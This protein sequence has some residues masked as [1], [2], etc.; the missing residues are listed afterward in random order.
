M[1]GTTDHTEL[2]SDLPHDL[3]TT[4]GSLLQGGAGPLL[5]PVRAEIFG[6]QRF[7]EHGQ[8]LGLTHAAGRAAWSSPSFF[9]RLRSN[10]GMLRLARQALAAQ[11]AAGDDVSPASLW[12]LDNFHLIEAQLLA[13]HEGLPRQYFRTLPVLLGEPLAG[14]PRIYGVAWAFVAH[15]DSAFDEDLLVHYLWAY[16]QTRELRVGL[17]V[18]Q[19]VQLQ[20]VGQVVNGAVVAQHGGH[21]HH[22]AVF[23]RN[24]LGQRQARQAA[25]AGGLTDDPVQ[26]RDDGL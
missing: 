19:V 2:P 23:G 1:A 6:P 26:Q 4:L 11:A 18:G 5:A 9:P 13:V 12:L 3:P 24:A 20:A 21:D 17:G 14:L 25:R 8:S 15:T 22:H 10:I 7:A 16:Q